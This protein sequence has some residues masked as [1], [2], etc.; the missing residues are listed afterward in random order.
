MGFYLAY[1]LGCRKVTTYGWDNDL[2]G[3]SHFNKKIKINSMMIREAEQAKKGEKEILS[4]FREKG[5]EINIK[6]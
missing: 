5:M 3:Q 2:S 4:F 6:R 1:H